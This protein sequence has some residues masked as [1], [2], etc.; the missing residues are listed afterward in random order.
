MIKELYSWLNNFIEII[1][2]F[3][4]KQLFE[5]LYSCSNNCFLVCLFLKSP[6]SLLAC[7][8]VVHLYTNWKLPKKPEM[9][10]DLS[11][12]VGLDSVGWV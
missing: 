3:D 7:F 4:D 5:Q 11:N 2:V 1:I 9:T 8:L 12:G 10:T 6:P